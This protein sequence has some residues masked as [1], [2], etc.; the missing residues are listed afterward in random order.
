MRE[1]KI[2]IILLEDHPMTLDGYLSKLTPARDIE[3]GPTL[4]YGEDLEPALAGYPADVLLMDLQVPTS[5]TN[6]NPFPVWHVLTRVVEKYPKLAIL[7]LSMFNSPAMIDNALEAG[8]NG[9]I[10]KD[11]IIAY[12][13][14]PAIVR[15]AAQ[16]SAY[17]SPSVRQRWLDRRKNDLSEPL[18][19]PRQ[20][21]ALSLCATYPN[22][23]LGQIAE[24]MHVA[25]STL[26]NLLS[27]A[28][29]KLEVNNRGAAVNLCYQHGLLVTNPPPLPFD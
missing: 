22:E 7:I 17:F 24:R 15:M 12:R 23:N 8:I 1:S 29:L 20:L 21:E 13:D 28:Y 18:L 25:Q 3:V 9:Y 2:K 19:S 26:R 5:P 27:R 14:L 16:G 11:D 10:L 6:S 4:S